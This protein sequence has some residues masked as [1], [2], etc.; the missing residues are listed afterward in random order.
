[1]IDM[2]TSGSTVGYSI[3]GPILEAH[4]T[5]AQ[6]APSVSEWFNP[7]DQLPTTVSFKCVLISILT[8]VHANSF[9]CRVYTPSAT[10]YSLV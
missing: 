10:N 9:V 2:V 8:S 6:M 7:L 1:M 5:I 4:D 3:N